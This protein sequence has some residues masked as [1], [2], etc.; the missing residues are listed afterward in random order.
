[1]YNWVRI[2]LLDQYCHRFLWWETN[3][4]GKPDQYILTTVTFGD[5]PGGANAMI[6]LCRTAQMSN[7]CL[8][9]SKLIDSNS[10]VDDLLTNVNGYAEAKVIMQEVDT[11]LKRGGFTMKEWIVS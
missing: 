4:K 1:M 7:D 5:G 10:Y 3:T 11:V 8:R 2:S 9:A 6:A